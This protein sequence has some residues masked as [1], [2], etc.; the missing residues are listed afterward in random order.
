MNKARLF[1][2]WGIASCALAVL[3]ACGGGSSVG[4][5][6][7]VR[8]AR[9][10]YHITTQDLKSV[11][12]GELA[13][14]LAGGLAG[15]GRFVAVGNKT[16]L[17][18]T[19]ADTWTSVSLPSDW[20]AIAFTHV[21]FDDA[22]QRFIAA[23][24]KLKN[25]QG[26]WDGSSVVVSSSDGQNWVQE[27]ISGDAGDPATSLMWGQVVGLVRTPFGDSNPHY[28]AVAAD[29]GSA[30]YSDAA[31]PK[32]S[33]KWWWMGDA[34]NGGWASSLAYDSKNARLVV[35]GGKQSGGQTSG[36]ISERGLGWATGGKTE[37]W[38]VQAAPDSRAQLQQ[39]AC[40]S[41]GECIAVGANQVLT[42]TAKADWRAATGIASAH[43][44]F[45]AQVAKGW[46]VAAG[47][48][49]NKGVLNASNDGGK[50]WRTFSDTGV[51]ANAASY[52][53]GIF[54]VVGNKGGI[55]RFSPQ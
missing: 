26:D 44:L 36:Q 17:T 22:A 9:A 41:E 6:P 30:Y 48:D 28:I 27:K 13:G 46:M 43:L 7:G 50:T 35:V 34:V 20:P 11:A 42:S 23:G 16:I 2:A 10:S 33:D 31:P 15:V 37:N 8:Q 14:E 32:L 18:S 51:Y 19:D 21:F 39:V 53:R 55:L 5:E 47:N 45:A 12:Y 24:P 3:S 40:N 25:D 29:K 54:V 4:S 52:G 49:G 38:T 1:G